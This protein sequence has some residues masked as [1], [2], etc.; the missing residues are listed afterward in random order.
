MGAP[1]PWRGPSFSHPSVAPGALGVPLAQLAEH[2]INDIFVVDKG[3][4]HASMTQGALFA[5]GDDLIGQALGLLGLGVGG[6]DT[7]ITQEVL[8]QVPVQGQAVA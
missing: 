8:D 7:L 6:L 1:S 3:Q 4:S 5:V 2:L